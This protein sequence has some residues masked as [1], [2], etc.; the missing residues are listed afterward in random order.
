MKPR[1]QVCLS[2]RLLPVHFGGVNVQPHVEKDEF[3][4]SLV[5]GERVPPEYRLPDLSYRVHSHTI[6]R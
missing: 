4:L 2:L 6:S 1:Y 3:R 5:G